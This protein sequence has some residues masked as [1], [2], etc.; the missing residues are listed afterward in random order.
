MYGIFIKRFFLFY[1]MILLLILGFTLS[2]DPYNKL[3]IN[4]FNIEYKLTRDD[5]GFKIGQINSMKQIDNLIIG[6]SRSQTLNPK[7]LSETLGGT[8]YNFG[9]GGGKIEDALGLLLYLE[10]EQKLPK[11]I[12]LCLDFNAFNANN[13]LHT[14]FLSSKELNFLN[15][16]V[17]GFEFAHFLSIDTIRSSVKTLKNHLKNKKPIHY[18]NEFGLIVGPDE[19]SDERKIKQVADSYFQTEYSNGEYS[20]DIRRLKWYQQFI[21]ITEE[22]NINLKVILTPIY[23]Y[24]YKM[25]QNNIELSEQYNLL[26]QQLK[27]KYPLDNLMEI[28]KYRSNLNYFA[29]SVHYKGE[30]GDIILKEIYLTN[31]EVN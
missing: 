13:K 14:K 7:I 9:V 11:N 3:G 15:K 17:N 5:R 19:I 8:S 25:I 28:E 26:L 12:L 24:Q 27:K 4:L 23:E 20:I 31:K 10:K 30:L 22:N 29:D 16:H 6:S 21:E 2:I 1:I 18:F